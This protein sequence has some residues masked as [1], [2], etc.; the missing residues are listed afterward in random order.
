MMENVS[1]KLLCE[2]TIPKQDVG[3]I[4]GRI[5]EDYAFN[6]L[7]D[8]LPAAEMQKNVATGEYFYSIGFAL[9]LDQENNRPALNNHYEIYIE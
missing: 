1:C 4:K 3:F 7:V 9:G 5:Q 8:G 6:W 2:S